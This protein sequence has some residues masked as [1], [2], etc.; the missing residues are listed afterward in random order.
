MKDNGLLEGQENGID[1]Y[2]V[3]I[4]NVLDNAYELASDIRELGYSVEVPYGKGKI[5]TFFK[6]AERRKAKF[7]L[8]IGESELEQGKVA[9]KNMETQQQ[10]EAD[11]ETLQETLDELFGENEHHHHD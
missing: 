9:L 7:A 3:P 6:K 5:G 11:I 4:G 2:V 8:I 1:L 10:I